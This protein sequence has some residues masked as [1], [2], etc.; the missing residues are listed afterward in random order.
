MILCRSDDCGA[1][2]RSRIALSF[3]TT[4]RRC[5][6]GRKNR[7]HS[8]SSYLS[9]ISCSCN[10]GVF[11]NCMYKRLQL[12]V[13]LLLVAGDH[14]KV[15]DAYVMIGRLFE[16]I[17]DFTQAMFY[18][19]RGLAAADKS[20]EKAYVAEVLVTNSIFYFMSFY[21]VCESFKKWHTRILNPK[22]KYLNNCKSA[23]CYKI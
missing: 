16:D 4:L 17:K 22:P 10:R 21:R 18:L 14:K 9:L 15:Y 6:D 5:R 20:G 19:M 11:Y 12:Q 8:N 7:F 3:G 13:V 23:L 1:V 2:D